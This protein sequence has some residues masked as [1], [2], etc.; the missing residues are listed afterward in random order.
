MKTLTVLSMT[1]KGYRLL[2][3]TVDE[4]RPLFK[5]VVI[6]RDLSLVD[7]YYEQTV[8]LCER[9]NIAWSERASGH[10]FATDYVV[11]IGWR[12]LVDFPE[13]RLVVF[14]DSLLPRYRGFNPLVTALINGDKKIGVTALFGAERF[15]SGPILAQASLDVSYPCTIAQA[16]E[17]IAACY[18]ETAVDVFEELRHDRPL[19]GI[20]QDETAATFSLWRDDADYRVDWSQP[21]EKLARFIDAVGSPYSGATT[22][23]NGHPARISKVEPIADVNVE[24]RTIGK[25][26]WVE[27]ACPVV[28]CGTGL[29]RVITLTDMETGASLLPLERFRSRFS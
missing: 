23:V 7:D 26:I 13:N 20:A 4:F 11:A 12:W 25:V 3:D 8:A 9:H 15:D 17:Q 6:G 14:H 22:L 5:H 10:A 1:K 24:N 21:A 28:V 2:A 27:S 16:I 18:A 29:L 19:Y